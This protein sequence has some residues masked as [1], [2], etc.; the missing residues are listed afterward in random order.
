MALFKSIASKL[1]KGL[2]KTH[3]VLTMDLRDLLRGKKLDEALIEEV[4]RR[5]IQADV[6]VK[7]TTRLIEGIQTDFRAGKMT[8]GDDVMEYLKRELKAMWPVQ[9]RELRFAP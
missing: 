2:A 9:D 6:G 3:E 5:L 7:T 4:R 8:R 1:K